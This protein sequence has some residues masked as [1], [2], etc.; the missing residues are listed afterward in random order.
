MILDFFPFETSCLGAKK[1]SQN[2]AE[3]L[4]KLL[5]DLTF[6]SC[7]AQSI[8]FILFFDVMLIFLYF[9]IDCSYTI[10]DM[11]IKKAIYL[12]YYSVDISLNLMLSIY[13]FS[14]YFFR[15]L[16]TPTD[17]PAGGV[18]A[19][20][21][22]EQAYRREEEEEGLR[23]LLLHRFEARSKLTNRK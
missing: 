8:Y 11:F 4:F 18:T 13:T 21:G 15:G 10:N 2:L 22:V 14:N 20:D 12:L 7:F 17:G 9:I 1:I 3:F 6:C 16:L 5:L 19:E 23:A